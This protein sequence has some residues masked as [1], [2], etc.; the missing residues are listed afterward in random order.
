MVSVLLSCASRNWMWNPYIGFKCL[1]NVPYDWLIPWFTACFDLFEIGMWISLNGLLRVHSI[2]GRRSGNIL[3]THLSFLPRRIRSSLYKKL[4]KVHVIVEVSDDS[5]FW[6]CENS[7]YFEDHFCFFLPSK[8][9]VE[10]LLVPKYLFDGLQFGIWMNKFFGV[11]P[12]S[13]SQKWIKPIVPVTLIR[14]FHPYSTAGLSPPLLHSSALG[15]L[16]QTNATTLL[17]YYYHSVHYSL[18]SQTQVST[19]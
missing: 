3:R 2:L 5:H 19:I 12:R 10:G 18:S 11:I 17:T 8:K 1:F 14:R 13:Q 6:I 15:E 9:T 7:P 16:L 4:C